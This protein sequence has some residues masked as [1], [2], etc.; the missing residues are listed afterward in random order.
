[1]NP[2]LKIAVASQN[3]IPSNTE[4]QLAEHL[5]LTL[6]DKSSVNIGDHDFILIYRSQ[7]LCLEK[8]GDDNL[9]PLCIDLLNSALEYRKKHHLNNELL[10]KAIGIRG[11]KSPS[12][13]DLTAGL[14][15]DS[16]ILSSAGC[17]VRMFERNPIVFVLLNDALQRAKNSQDLDDNIV[18]QLNAIDLCQSDSINEL[19]NIEVVRPD[20]IY[21]DPMFPEKKK[22]AK[23]KKAMQYCQLIVGK[24]TDSDLLLDA[25]LTT[26][27]YRVVVKRPKAAPILNE[28]RPSNQVMGKT[29]RYDVYS[30]K[31]TTHY[32]EEKKPITR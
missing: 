18:Q 11:D 17:R 23:A 32:L 25:A 14:G 4:K 3:A 16:M 31:S 7:G 5:G 28:K 22:N 2:S 19:N 10:V 21:I 9:G 13:W 20:I 26:A 24:D 6:C 27:Q 8:V 30:I 1:M 12:V 15:Q 29:V